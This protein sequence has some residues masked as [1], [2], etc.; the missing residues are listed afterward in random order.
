MVEN[1]GQYIGE[2]EK[3]SSLQVLSM[4]LRQPLLLLRELISPPGDTLLYLLGQGLPLMFVP[5]LTVDTWLLMGLPLLGL[6]LAQGSNN[7]L[8]INIRYT[9][10]VVPGLFAGAVLWWQ[11]HQPL[12][13]SSRRLRRVWAGCILLSL[14]FALASN[15]NRSLSFLIPDSIDPWVHRNPVEQWRHGIAAREVLR[16]IP[17]G[18]PA[19]ASTPLVPRLAARPVLVRFP[20]SIEYLDRQGRVRRVEWIAA[21]LAWMRR[22]APA[23]RRERGELEDSRE[24]F[25]ELRGEYGV[26]R[27]EDGLVILQRG[28]DDVPGERQ[29]LERF[30]RE[31]PLRGRS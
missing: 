31:T 17:A 14:L 20:R 30:L 26:R 12:F 16:Q 22:Y 25:E 2:R 15:P 3:A 29:A 6:L 24:L 27:F 19:A 11:R 4:V 8:S 9:L 5:Y 7:P 10:L 28:A 23:F 21:D 13:R 18:A 1:F